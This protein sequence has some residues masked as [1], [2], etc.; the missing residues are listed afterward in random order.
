MLKVHY[1]EGLSSKPVTEYLTVLHDGWAGEKAVNTLISMC[2]A[3]GVS[4]PFDKD[5]A[6]AADYLNQVLPPA[7][8]RHKKD[9]KYH[10][11]IGRKWN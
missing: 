1:Y 8:I 2:S 4:P 7:V 11:I 3:A 10:R 9:G 5:L 6:G